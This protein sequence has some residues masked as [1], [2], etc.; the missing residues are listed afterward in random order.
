MIHQSLFRQIGMFFLLPLC[1]AVIH[2]IFGIQFVLKSF[3]VT[4]DVKDI[5]PSVIATAVFLIIIYGGY[6]IATYTQSKQ[7]V[8]EKTK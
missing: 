6:F 7:I 8:V 5:L 4:I 1:L 3:S 2:S